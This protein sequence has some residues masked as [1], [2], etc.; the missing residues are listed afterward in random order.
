MRVV[1]A[2]PWK[3]LKVRNWDEL[4]VSVHH[5][6]VGVVGDVL[7]TAAEGPIAAEGVEAFLHEQIQRKVTWEA[8]RSGWLDKLLLVVGDI[9]GEAVARLERVSDIEFMDDGQLE[10]GHQPPG[11]K[12]VGCI[13][14]IGTSSLRAEDGTVDV[15]IEYLVGV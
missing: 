9:E 3:S 10:K 12:A 1:K 5:G 6:G 13:P 7:E 2:R 8:E 4:N 15:E 14:G 11:K